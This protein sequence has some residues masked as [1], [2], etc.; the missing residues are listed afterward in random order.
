MKVHLLSSEQPSGD[1]LRSPAGWPG[2]DR[3]REFRMQM[4]G[5]VALSAI[6]T[7]SRS[8]RGQTPASL[9]SS[10]VGIQNAASPLPESWC[11][12][13]PMC[14]AVAPHVGTLGAWSAFCSITS[15]LL[16]TGL[17]VPYAFGEVGML[18]GSASLF[19]VAS[20]VAYGV[21]LVTLSLCSEKCNKMAREEN[22][23]LRECE[24]SFLAYCA[25]GQ[26][27][28]IITSLVLSIELWFALV[29]G[30]VS[31]GV[32][33]SLLTHGAF[34]QAFVITMTTIV[35][36]PLLD[37]PAWLLGF[38]GVCALIGTGLC[39]AGF[40]DAAVEAWP[41]VEMGHDNLMQ[42]TASPPQ[43]ALSQFLSFISATGIFVYGYG[44]A[45]CLPPIRSEMKSTKNFPI[46][47]AVAMLV[48]F[49][50]YCAIGIAATPFGDLIGQSYLA[51]V[52]RPSVLTVACL[53]VVI[54]FMF[55]MP[56]LTNPILL[57]LL[58]IVKATTGPQIFMFKV[59]FSFVSAAAA[60]FLQ[61]YLAPLSSLTG[62]S[63]SIMT[64]V[65]M[66]A[67]IYVRLVPSVSLAEKVLIASVTAFSMVFVVFGTYVAALDI[68][69]LPGGLES[70]GGTEKVLKQL[71]P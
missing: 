20:V 27:G 7:P 52:T 31:I 62:A 41:T 8:P 54:S 18:V 51:N 15:A 69:G 65:I 49:F 57:A 64:L 33:G 38:S 60:I 56:L 25:Y 44:N 32:N 6:P 3:W 16:G 48:S 40:F 4:Q 47:A 11:P 53:S 28:R 12:D 22:V 17:S 10:P 26:R 61:D 55:V 58:P 67:G 9:V 2:Q 46:V 23:D 59:T 45:A 21:R 35:M 68:F 66:P 70:L 42:N 71:S 37:A 14:D 29:V 24:L 43:S 30:L 5:A 36:F 34:S 19:V 50:F 39:A 63:L 13:I 1:Y